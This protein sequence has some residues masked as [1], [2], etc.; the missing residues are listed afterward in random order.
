MNKGNQP[1]PSKGLHDKL[2]QVFKF[3]QWKL[4]LSLECFTVS[5][6]II[7]RENIVD[8]FAVL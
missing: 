8:C 4:M 3:F 2:Q 5:D 1:G 7:L 6:Q